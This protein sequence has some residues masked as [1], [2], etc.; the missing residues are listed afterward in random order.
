M[1]IP[2]L[3]SKAKSKTTDCYNDDFVVMT[4]EELEIFTKLVIE[5]ASKVETIE[6]IY[7]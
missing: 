5:E 6:E 2:E 3:V 7:E 1:N 4:N